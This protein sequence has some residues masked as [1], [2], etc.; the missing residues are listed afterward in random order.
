MN[1]RQKE[2]D[3]PELLMFTRTRSWLKCTKI[4]SNTASNLVFTN[5]RVHAQRGVDM[6]ITSSIRENAYEKARN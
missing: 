6:M 2:V 5:V 1:L 3:F 4:T